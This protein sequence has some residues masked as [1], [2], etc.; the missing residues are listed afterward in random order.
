MEKKNNLNLPWTFR[1]LTAFREILRY[2]QTEGH[3]HTDRQTSCYLY[4]RIKHFT[5]EQSLEP[6]DKLFAT[7]DVTC[8]KGVLQDNL[9]CLFI[10]TVGFISDI[11]TRLIA[12]FR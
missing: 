4:I 12:S 10:D 2:R 5:G 7:L 1:Q 3:S 6:E 9:E 11:P 8:H